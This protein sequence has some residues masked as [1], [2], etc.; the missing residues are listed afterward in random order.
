MASLPSDAICMRILSVK[1][2]LFAVSFINLVQF[3]LA[4]SLHIVFFFRINFK[5]IHFSLA[6]KIENICDWLKCLKQEIGKAMY[7]I[8]HYYVT[9]KKTHQG[10]G[11]RLSSVLLGRTLYRRVSTVT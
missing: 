4:T 8:Y 10:I 5:V 1:F 9:K 3:R 7:D 2:H 6:F 11:A